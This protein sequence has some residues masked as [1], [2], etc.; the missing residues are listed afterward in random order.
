MSSQEAKERVIRD[1]RLPRFPV[2]IKNPNFE[3]IK[4][5]FNTNDYAQWAGMSA[6]SF[7]LGYI[8]GKSVV[9]NATTYDVEKS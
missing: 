2:I 4:G 5:N 3:Q 1:P 8:F 9:L 6:V 7:P